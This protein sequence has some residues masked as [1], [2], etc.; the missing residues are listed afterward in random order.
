MPDSTKL[1]GYRW[2]SFLRYAPMRVG[3]YSGVCMT[4][5]FS[6]WVLVAN[7]VPFLEPLAM[8]RNVAAALALCFF[9]SLPILRFYRASGDLLA[10]GLLGWSILTL[11]YLLLSVKFV[12]LDGEYSAFH[13]FVM[14]AVIY[15]IAATL[16]WIGSIIWRTRAADI[17]H[18]HR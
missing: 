3:I 10:S 18:S 1:P 9:A 12:L 17:Y 2:F 6:F 14:G 7:R 13:V 5:V 4:V 11:A 8:Q 16:S 15:L